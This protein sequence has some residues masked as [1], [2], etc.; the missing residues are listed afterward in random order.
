[1]GSESFR[2]CRS[3]NSILPA[4]KLCKPCHDGIII[5]VVNVSHGWSCTMSDWNDASS[6]ESFRLPTI[7]YTSEPGSSWRHGEHVGRHSTVVDVAS[8]TVTRCLAIAAIITESC[9][10]TARLDEP[11]R[12]AIAEPDATEWH[13]P[14]QLAA[15]PVTVDD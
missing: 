11:S 15:R 1:M 12:L 4:S 13:A 9:H 14:C 3:G 5:D 2:S 6:C 7:Y 8:Y 10:L